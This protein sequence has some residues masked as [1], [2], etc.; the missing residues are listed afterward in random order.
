MRC[1][2]LDVSE[3]RKPPWDFGN[4]TAVAVPILLLIGA[5]VRGEEKTLEDFRCFTSGKESGKPAVDQAECTEVSSPKR[6][7]VRN[8]SP[9][10]VG[11]PV[12]ELNIWDAVCIHPSIYRPGHFHLLM[13]TNGRAASAASGGQG[14]LIIERQ[15]NRNNVAFNLEPHII[16]GCASGVYEK[17][18]SFEWD[19]VREVLVARASD[20]NGHIG[21][22]LLGPE[23]AL[24]RDALGRCLYARF[25]RARYTF[26]RT[27]GSRGL[28]NGLFNVSNMRFGTLPEPTGREPQPNGGGGQDQRQKADGVHSHL[29]QVMPKAGDER[30]RIAKASGVVSIILMGLAGYLSTGGRNHW[31]ESAMWLCAAVG[32]MALGFA[33]GIG[34]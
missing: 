23:V 32:V 30:R 26:H 2:R 11:L 3:L 15:W 22:H 18:A 21:P 8:G 7:P 25:K 16:S 10:V 9:N 14:E 13:R 17:G 4:L 1:W 34:G 19:V 31:S 6:V 28:G 27:S 12:S 29:V 24:N 5:V 20:A 33:A